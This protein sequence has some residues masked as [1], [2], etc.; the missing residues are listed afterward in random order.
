M[1]V[2]K[3]LR[4][5]NP[6]VRII[7]FDVDP[8]FGLNII[9]SNHEF[10]LGGVCEIDPE[11]FKRE[12]GICAFIWASPPCTQYS[13]ARSYAKTERD[14]YR[15]NFVVRAGMRIIECLRPD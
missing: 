8:K 11:E 5:H 4:L 6:S 7:S 2:S 3:A 15:A 10:R 13:I 14:L 1:P 12:V 9:D